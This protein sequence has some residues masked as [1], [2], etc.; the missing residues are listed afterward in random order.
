MTIDSAEEH[1]ALVQSMVAR[2]MSAAWTAGSDLGL[3]DTVR[4]LK[5]SRA[6]LC[7]GLNECAEFPIYLLIALNHGRRV[8]HILFDSHYHTIAL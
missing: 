6:P 7:L 1:N 4:A 5:P 3:E 2:D 8:P